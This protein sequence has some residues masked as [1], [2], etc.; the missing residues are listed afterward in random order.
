[1]ERRR[2]PRRSCHVPA[3][4]TLL[5]ET[6]V[7]AD[8][9][10]EDVSV[11]GISITTEGGAEV[12]VEEW[13]ATGAR[14]WSPRAVTP[15]TLFQLK[16]SDSIFLGEIVRC[17]PDENGYQYGVQFDQCL[18]TVTALEQ[19]LKTLLEEQRGATETARSR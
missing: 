7:A 15:G 13:S 8:V 4:L 10:L 11:D 2:N 5:A 19:L 12:M 17:E 14:I 9:I 18:S 1:M 16:C 6:P 3:R